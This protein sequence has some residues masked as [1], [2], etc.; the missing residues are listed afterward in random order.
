MEGPSPD[1]DASLLVPSEEGG[2]GY[3]EATVT[4]VIGLLTWIHVSGAQVCFQVKL[5]NG[6]LGKTGK[7]AFWN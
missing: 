7:I 4:T 5:H 6:L 3:T 1:E 2:K